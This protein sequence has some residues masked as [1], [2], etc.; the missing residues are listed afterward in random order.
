MQLALPFFT[1]EDICCLECVYH[2]TDDEL[3]A[4]FNCNAC[5][6]MPGLYLERRG[7]CSC[8]YNYFVY[9]GA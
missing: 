4:N 7:Q 9:R 2:R 8:F 3:C 1:E 6:F 5:L